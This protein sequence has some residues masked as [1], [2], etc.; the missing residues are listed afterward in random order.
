M[1][2]GEQAQKSWLSTAGWEKDDPMM[3]DQLGGIE[4]QTVNGQEVTVEKESNNKAYNKRKRWFR[5]KDKD[6]EYTR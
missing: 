3:F 4:T 2:F 5:T 6:D 1:S